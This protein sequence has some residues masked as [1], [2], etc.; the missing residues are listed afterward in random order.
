MRSLRVFICKGHNHKTLACNLIALASKQLTLYLPNSL[1][2]YVFDKNIYMHSNYFVNQTLCRP[3][4]PR[5]KGF[6][7]NNRFLDFDSICA[8]NRSN[9]S[10]TVNKLP[11]V[12]I[13]QVLGPTFKEDNSRECIFPR[14]L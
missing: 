13:P 6:F 5:K 2:T 1:K 7:T 11:T 14:L 12:K 3:K 10:S 8:E 9:S 4:H